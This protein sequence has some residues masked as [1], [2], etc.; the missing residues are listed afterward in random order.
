MRVAE[1]SRTSGVPVPSIK[2]Y[3]RA[4][5]L[6]PGERT[7]PNQA[8]YDQAHVHRLRLIRALIEVGGL[9][10]A[11]VKEVL[12]AMDDGGNNLNSALGAAFKATLPVKQPDET[13]HTEAARRTAAEL[14]AK[15]DWCVHDDSPNHE[16][17]VSAL[18]VLYRLGQND[19]GE[20]VEAYARHADELGELEVN[21]VARQGALEEIVEAAVVGTFIGGAV[22]NAMRVIVHE[23]VSQRTLDTD[24]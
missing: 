6:P 14:I 24:K 1:L 18:A 11:S 19:V 22:F 9:S 7:A 12:E 3:L 20:I 16:T 13:E 23:S 17:L 21:W 8:D 10:V 2:Y 4:G 5:L 15:H